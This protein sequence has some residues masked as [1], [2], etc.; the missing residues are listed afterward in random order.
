MGS[1]QA[2]VLLEGRS[3]EAAVRALAERFGRDL[4]AEGVA[5]EVVGG[6]GGFARVMAQL[7]PGIAVAA[8]V[9]VGEVAQAGAALA[10]L[11]L[12]DDLESLGFH[13]CHADLEDELIRAL[14]TDVV[15][16]VV[17]AAGEIRQLRTFQDQPFQRERPLD[18]Q[19]R[20][21][22]GTKSGRK[23]RY[24]RLLVEALDL[25]RV[26]QPLDRVLAA[27]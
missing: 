10:R 26:P 22:L 18:A 8:L 15:V 1:V 19:L 24:G 4:D 20:R 21:F 2:V 17:R 3:D 5:V 23:I 9:D 25:T 12:G 27:V 16:E 6:A 11:G 13:V 7:D 14:G